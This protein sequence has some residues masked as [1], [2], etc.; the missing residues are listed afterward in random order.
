MRKHFKLT[1]PVAKKDSNWTSSY[2]N[3][4]TKC[5]NY[6]N[7]PVDESSFIVSMQLNKQSCT[8]VKIHGKLFKAMVDTGSEY[9]YCSESVAKWLHQNNIAMTRYPSNLNIVTAA[10]RTI[11]L[12]NPKVF[13]FNFAGRDSSFEVPLTALVL[14]HLSPDLVIGMS[15]LNSLDAAITFEATNDLSMFTLQNLNDI[16][17]TPNFQKFL[18]RPTQILPFSGHVSFTCKIP[19][20][21]VQQS[22]T[23][24]SPF[25]KEYA[26][27]LKCRGEDNILV[28]AFTGKVSMKYVQLKTPVLSFRA[29]RNEHGILVPSLATPVNSHSVEQ[30]LAG[31]YTAVFLM[32]PETP[33]KDIKVNENIEHEQHNCPELVDASV[34]VNV[35]E[36]ML[37]DTDCRL[38]KQHKDFM[39][40][41]AKKEFL[42]MFNFPLTLSPSQTHKL[43][44]V[45]YK[46][47]VAFRPPDSNLVLPP[48]KVTPITLPLKANVPTYRKPRPVNYWSV[49]KIELVYNEIQNLVKQGVLQET[50]SNFVSDILLV[51]KPNGQV[52]MCCD[53]RPCNEYLQTMVST[54]PDIKTLIQSLGQTQ[55][56][57]QKKNF[58]STADLSSAFHQLPLSPESSKF[59][60]IQCPK[61]F[62]RYSYRRLCFGCSLSPYFFQSKMH[63]IFS[64]MLNKDLFLFC[65]DGTLAHESFED[66]LKAIDKMLSR[67]AEYSLS[68]NP[69]KSSFCAGS[70]K[71]LAHDIFPEGYKPHEAKLE[72]GRQIKD[73][74]SPKELASILGFFT[75]FKSSIRDFSHLAADLFKLSKTLPNEFQWT[76][77]HSKLLRT[78]KENFCNGPILSY[79][80][81]SKPF[82]LECDTSALATGSM[83]YQLEESDGKAIKRIIAFGGN[84]LLPRQTRYSITEL[85]LTGLVNALLTHQQHLFGQELTVY[86]DHQA[87]IPL[88]KQKHS[89]NNRVNRFIA[90]V[91]SF[92]PKVVYR[93]GKD[94]KVADFL[95][96]MTTWPENKLEQ[97]IH[98]RL[99]PAESYV[100]ITDAEQF[101]TFNKLS[102]SFSQTDPTPFST[103]ELG[104]AQKQDP[105]CAAFINFL[106]E[107]NLSNLPRSLEKEVLLTAATY[108]IGPDHLLYKIDTKGSTTRQLLVVPNKLVPTVLKF[109]HD[110]K[111]HSGVK[112]TIA[113]VKLKFYWKTLA[114]DVQ[115]KIRY[116]QT[117]QNFKSVSVFRS[118]KTT[119]FPVCS[120]GENLLLDC[121]GP[122][123]NCNGYTQVL[124]LMDEASRF[125]TLVPLKDVSAN[126]VAMAVCQYFWTHGFAK[127]IRADNALNFQN[128]LMSRICELL[129]IENIRVP[130]YSGFTQGA[131]ERAIG[132]VKSKM[133]CTLEGV[134]QNWVKVLPAVAYAYNTSPSTTFGLDSGITS[135]QLFF[136]RHLLSPVDLA[137]P[138]SDVELPQNCVSQYS[139]LVQQLIQAQLEAKALMLANKESQEKGRSYNYYEGQLVQVLVDKIKTKDTSLMHKFNRKYIGPFMVAKVVSDSVVQLAN[140]ETREALKNLIN[141][142]YIRPYFHR[143]QAPP[144]PEIDLDLNDPLPVLSTEYLPT[145]ARIDLA[146]GVGIT[147]QQVDNTVHMLKHWQPRVMAPVNL[148]P[149]TWPL[150][151]AQANKTAYPQVNLP[152]VA[153]AL[154]VRSAQHTEPVE[155]VNEPP[156]EQDQ[157]PYFTRSMVNPGLRKD[158]TQFFTL[159]PTG[160]IKHGYGCTTADGWQL[161]KRHGL[162]LND[163]LLFK[164]PKRPTIGQSVLF[165]VDL[166]QLAIPVYESSDVLAFDTSKP[167]HINADSVMLVYEII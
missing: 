85:E 4:N 71:F 66:H 28:R 34:Q 150:I 162:V 40:L 154:A 88:L 111:G 127:C 121:M 125:I 11:T 89:V 69:E 130:T 58:Y 149:A 100:E 123:Q 14:P 1:S 129:N 96:R 81:Y 32:R 166:I 43:K 75:F 33:S 133:C 124:V 18:F 82:Y 158:Y 72:F 6:N 46:N 119:H 47:R 167:H 148:L 118:S 53:L 161:I 12:R 146:R 92:N 21:E 63:D 10:Q 126:S 3:V 159:Q 77:T 113:S 26:I 102:S 55:K 137:F 48:A 22:R 122:F 120:V 31:P 114:K 38:Q 29:K 56:S 42:Q 39:T 97:L 36:V 15:T 13:S 132:T 135:A 59:I 141:I 143:L 142:R 67:M 49:E 105:Y 94:M 155:H 79:P 80:D 37:N 9:T 60:T 152:P 61:T 164:T 70:T 116:C 73:P 84:K 128:S 44:E 65:D 17:V 20:V 35:E 138:K 134:K 144:E 51:P 104:M 151:P 115:D 27:Y 109:E 140:A 41:M 103:H 91:V 64:D 19:G 110:G 99:F 62:K 147:P 30:V 50:E 23:T 90:T 160:S 107:D 117:C 153:P 24:F 87:L 157:N 93:P 16:C 95:S 52:R 106:E 108:L 76:P 156:V 163:I 139:D 165:R 54:T 86:T 5:S 78:I 83:L 25:A 101:T 2:T 8:Y 136:G 74:T 112:A 57:G 7:V 45:L 145:E 68:V 131:I 98:K